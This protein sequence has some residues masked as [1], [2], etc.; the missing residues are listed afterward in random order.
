MYPPRNHIS[1][2]FATRTPALSISGTSF[3]YGMKA[4]LGSMKSA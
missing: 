2:S 1:W 3:A 4:V